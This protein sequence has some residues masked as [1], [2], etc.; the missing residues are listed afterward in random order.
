MR[1]FQHDEYVIYHIVQMVQALVFCKNVLLCN[2]KHAGS[3]LE[4]ATIFTARKRSLR[5]LCFRR[6]L[7]VHR[8]STWAG[9]PPRQAHPTPWAGTPPQ[10]HLPGQVHPLGRYPPSQVT[11]LG[12]YPPLGHTACWDMV[13]QAGGLHFTGMHSCI[14]IIEVLSVYFP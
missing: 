5:R 6:C 7:S 8:E 2:A 11:P 13:K 10:V 4:K 3:M 14:I 1:V 9:I 12:R